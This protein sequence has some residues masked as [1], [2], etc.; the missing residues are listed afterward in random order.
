MKISSIFSLLHIFGEE[1]A[2][3]EFV[4]EKGLLYGPPTCPICEDEMKRC[5]YLYRCSK[6]VCRREGES[7]SIRKGSFFSNSRLEIRKILMIIYCFLSGMGVSTAQQIAGVGS[8][9]I[10]N[11]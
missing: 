8:E 11:W 2:A 9:S 7:V 3:I 10:V 6:K 1:E 5:Q 4:L